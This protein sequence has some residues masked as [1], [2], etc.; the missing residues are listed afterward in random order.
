MIPR[1]QNITR[2]FRNAS[3]ADTLFGMDWYMRARRLAEDLDPARP[4]QAAGVIAALSPLTSW[5]LNVRNAQD[6]YSGLR[7]R[8]LTK[9]AEKAD[10]IYHGADPLDILGGEKVVSFFWNIIAPNNATPV[11]IDRHAIDIAC[12]RVQSDSERAIAIRG[13]S[14]YQ[15]VAGMYRRASEILSKEYNVA[16]LPQQV[17][18]VTW[19]SWRNTMIRNNHGDI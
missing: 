11:T 15:I 8:T 18:A 7:A 16:I 3:K 17:Q 19:V 5:P 1:T 2:V 10:A 12:G 6:V 14:G 13:K 4:R 9:N